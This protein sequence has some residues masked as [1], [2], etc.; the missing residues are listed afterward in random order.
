[1]R[2][3]VGWGRGGGHT[4]SPSAE[5]S[6]TSPARGTEAPGQRPGEVPPSSWSLTPSLYI[7][8]G[9]TKTSLSQPHLLR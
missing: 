8:L 4:P 2:Q 7:N 1:M 5:L 9:V 6:Y 3:E